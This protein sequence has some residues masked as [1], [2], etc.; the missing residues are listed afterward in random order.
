MPLGWTPALVANHSADG[1]LTT[2]S[3][4][5]PPSGIW[6]G[7]VL[8]RCGPAYGLDKEISAGSQHQNRVVLDQLQL[9]TGD[10]CSLPQGQQMPGVPV[11]WEPSVAWSSGSCSLSAMGW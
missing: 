10:G 7:H 6:R 5:Q 4:G 3:V 8:M 11:C 2:Y 1:A 9:P